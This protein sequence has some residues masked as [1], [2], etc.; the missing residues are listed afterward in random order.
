[1]ITLKKDETIRQTEVNSQSWSSS[2]EDT[3][4]MGTP[5]FK[6]AYRPFN[7]TYL[8]GNMA[9]LYSKYGR[10]TS[11]L[12]FYQQYVSDTTDDAPLNQRGRS[13]DELLEF[14]RTYKANYENATGDLSV[15]LD[16]YYD[17]L[18]YHLFTETIRG[19]AAEEELINAINKNSNVFKAEG[20]DYLMDTLYG[21]DIKVTTAEGKIFYV[22]VK[23][24][25]FIRGK[26]PDKDLLVD[27]KALLDKR[28]KTLNECNAD[29]LYAF[30]N[31]TY[32]GREWSVKPNGRVLYRVDEILTADGHT[33]YNYKANHWSSIK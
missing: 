33:L 30:Y 8:V 12:D 10:P 24:V 28:I 4:W 16:K 19:H 23:P 15:P 21:V 1:M 22:Q 7:N 31:N 6:A 14:A 25:S 18:C 11:T 9:Y 32:A 26:N 27:R 5:D 13:E 29:T 17:N 2:V 3:K 20:V